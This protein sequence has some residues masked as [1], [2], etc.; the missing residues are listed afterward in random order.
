MEGSRTLPEAG[1]FLTGTNRH[2][3]QRQSTCECAKRQAVV[4]PF[5]RTGCEVLRTAYCRCCCCWGDTLP[6]QQLHVP[7]PEERN[8][9]WGT[10]GMEPAPANGSP[11]PAGDR[12]RARSRSSR[13]QWLSASREWGSGPRHGAPQKTKP[14]TS[15]RPLCIRTRC[16]QTVVGLIRR[17]PEKTPDPYAYD[18]AS[19]AKAQAKLAAEPQLAG[20]QCLWTRDPT[21]SSGRSSSSS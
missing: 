6:G 4:G 5:Y 21:P 3:P 1:A 13:S 19:Q 15:W 8:S 16:R 14:P 9:I 7:R 20:P 12:A 2:R 11:A 18:P 10:D 17:M